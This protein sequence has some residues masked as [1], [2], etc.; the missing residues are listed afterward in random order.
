MDALEFLKQ[1]DNESV[2]LV[3]TDPPYYNRGTKSVY[4]RKGH[5]DVIT[6]FG[7]WD[8]F[9]DDEEFLN[10]MQKIISEIIRIL[11]DNGSFYIF[12]NDRYNSFLR[13]FIRE[14][15]N[16]K[17]AST[18]VWHKYNSPPRFIEK[19]GFISSKELILFG[20]K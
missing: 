16:T 5:T 4:S 2:D 12:C 10:F 7:E 17:F 13:K 15:N 19:A 18:I 3:L 20:Y 11:K 8:D 14:L 1:I 6:D 9:N